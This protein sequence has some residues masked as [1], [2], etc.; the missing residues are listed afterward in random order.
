MT[1]HRSKAV[2]FL[3]YT[4]LTVGI[5]IILIPFWWMI[6][7]SFDKLNSAAMPNPPRLLPLNWSLYNYEVAINNVNMVIATRNNF[8]LMI[9]SFLLNAALASAAGFALSKGRFPFRNTLLVFFLSCQMVP[10]ESRVIE[11][12]KLINNVGLSDSFAG[13]LLPGLMTNAFYIFLMKKAFGD[14]PDSLME[15]AQID[16]GSLFRIYARIY[17]PLIAPV[18]AALGVLDA[19]AIWNDMLW[20]LLVLKSRNL[21]TVQ[22]S[23]IR[24]VS[25]HPG[26]LSAVVVLSVVPISIVFLVFQ[27]W[28][29]QGIATSGL[30]G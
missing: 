30:K 20:P 6:T 29:I 18:V 10:F 26:V 17:L 16:G 13:Y 11:I 4:I 28:I 15:S 27:K 5:L 19:V 9:C 12:F 8:I 7:T 22:L 1:R 23:M 14:M 2:T 24:Y 25:S 3:M 21:Y